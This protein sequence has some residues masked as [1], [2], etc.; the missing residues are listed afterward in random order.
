MRYATKSR[1]DYGWNQ[2][3]PTLP[4]AKNKELSLLVNDVTEIRSGSWQAVNLISGKSI[5]NQKH[6]KMDQDGNNDK[7]MN[8]FKRSDMQYVHVKR[9]RQARKL[10]KVACMCI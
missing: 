3:S 8:N 2:L 7:E 1:N 5:G 10:I 9:L 4:L 6:V